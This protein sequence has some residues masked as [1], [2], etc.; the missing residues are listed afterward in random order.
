VL[1]RV[2]ARVLAD[3]A[4]LLAEPLEQ[5]PPSPASWQAAGARI[6]FSGPFR[7]YVEI[8]ASR[9]TARKLAAN[10]LGQDPADPEIDEAHGDALMETLNV[11]CGNLLTELAGQEPV[12]QLGTPRTCSGFVP[13]SE[14]EP[15]VDAWLE[16]DGQPVLMRMRVVEQQPQIA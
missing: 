2:A 6:M 15:G 12:F 13:F 5:P 8:W 3:A 1:E 16:A 4:F 11:I 10:M 14:R 7:G 9:E